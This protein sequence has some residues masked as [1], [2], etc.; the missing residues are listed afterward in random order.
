VKPEPR[1]Q[2]IANESAKDSDDEVGDDAEARAAQNQTGQPSGYQADEQDGEETFVRHDALRRHRTLRKN[3]DPQADIG[4][5][6]RRMK[7]QR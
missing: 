2:P 6:H 3:P 7:L 4:A 1:Q 5:Y